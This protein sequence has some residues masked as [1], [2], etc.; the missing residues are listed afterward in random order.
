MDF[1]RLL[2]RGDLAGA[3]GPDGLVGDDNARGH[4]LAHALE[5]A[6]KLGLH[7]L[8]RRTRFALREGLADA[9]DRLQLGLERSHHLLVDECVVLAEVGSPLAVAED[10]VGR[11]QRAQHAARKSRR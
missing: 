2:R 7:D 4:F 10:D 9:E 5:C 3:D 1:L 6:L 11:E 8:E